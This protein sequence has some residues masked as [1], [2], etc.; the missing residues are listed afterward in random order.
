MP[1]HEELQRRT[2]AERA[3]LLSVPAIANCL[4]G[5]VTR[6]RYVAFL[7][8]AYHHVKHTVP[9]LMACGSRFGEERAP[10]RAAMAQY[11]A[12]ENAT[13]NGSST[14]CAPAVTTRRRRGARRPPP[15]PS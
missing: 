1:F 14:T 11:I 13:S 15:P 5:R 4:A 3:E 6:A 9:L 8:Q 2:A 10:L 12:E 7:R